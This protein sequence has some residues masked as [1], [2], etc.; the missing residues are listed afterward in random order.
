MD[1]IALDQAGIGEAVAPLGTALTEAQLER[2]WRLDPARSSAS[3]ATAP[4]RRPRSAPPCA[5]CPISA[6]TGP[7]AS[8]TFPPARI[9]TISSAAGGRDALEALLAEPEP[10]VDRLWRH[11]L[12]AAAADH[13]R[14]ARRPPPA[15]D[16]P[17]RSDRRPGPRASLPR[18]L[19]RPLQRARPPPQQPFAPAPA[20]ASGSSRAAASCR[21]QRP[22]ATQARASAAAASTPEHARALVLGFAISRSRSPPM[23]R[24]SP[25]FRSPTRPRPLRD[26]LV[27]AAVLRRMLDRETLAT[28][29][30]RD[31]SGG[32]LEKAAPDRNDG[33]FLH[34]PRQRPDRAVRD[35]GTAI[36]CVGGGRGDRMPPSKRRPSG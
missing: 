3:T 29:L 9:P 12:A 5:R 36:E 26:A 1:V 10:L 34:P 18:R 27:D 30:A 16:R 35:L 24:R 6:R 21:P 33:L 7:S 11:E 22:S 31:W 2:L 15:P 8:S 20:G 4:G 13:A 25:P 23:P 14:S 32:R 17:C 28:I 19:A